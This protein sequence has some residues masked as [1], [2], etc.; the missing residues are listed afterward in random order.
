MR[1]SELT[2]EEFEAVLLQVWRVHVTSGEQAATDRAPAVMVV[3]APKERMLSVDVVDGRDEARQ[4]ISAC[5]KSPQGLVPV[6]TFEAWM[7]TTKRS[8]PLPEGSVSKMEG[9][10]SAIMTIAQ[11]TDGAIVIS[12]QLSHNDPSDDYVRTLGNIKSVG[13]PSYNLSGGLVPYAGI[14]GYA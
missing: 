6:F 7:A 14:V 12:G 11:F 2:R 10:K 1:Q 9:A 13:V 4:V 8:E 5:V 3:L